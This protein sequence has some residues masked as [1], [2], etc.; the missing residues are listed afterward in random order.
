[1]S[2]E[3]RNPKSS[4]K[5][6]LTLDCVVKK[7]IRNGKFRC[8]G[9][10]K[11][12]M[13]SETILSDYSRR[14][15]IENGIKDLIHSYFM[16]KRPGTSP[17]LVNVHF[18]IVTICRQI[19]RMIQRDLGEDIKNADGSVKSLATM[20]DSLFLQGSSRVLFRAFA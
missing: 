14:W 5:K 8:F 1:M 6:T 18:L 13:T 16:D 10:S 4:D 7:N 15:I 17:H 20:R 3:Y 19:Y 12:G 9:T 11:T 2:W